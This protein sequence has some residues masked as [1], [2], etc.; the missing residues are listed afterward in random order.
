[1][2]AVARFREA[3]RVRLGDD[4]LIAEIMEGHERVTDVS[5]KE[6]RAAFFVDAMKRMDQ[7]LD[8]ET[9]RDIRDVC[10]C[11]KGGWRLKAVQEV[12][13]KCEGLGLGERLAALQQVTHMGKP[14]LNDD[15][16]I[17]ASIGDQGGFPCP[18][19][20]FSGIEVGEPVSSTYCLCCAGHFRHHYQI[21]LGRELVCREVQSSALESQGTKPCRLVYEIVD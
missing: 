21:A 11:S 20:V 18:C 7:L 16:T 9:R 13:N 19:P 10:A 14:V 15:G 8:F 5:K 12:A 2:G 6:R 17:T 1:M 4:T 3:L